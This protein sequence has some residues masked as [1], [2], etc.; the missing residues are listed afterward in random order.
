MPSFPSS[1]S[2][3]N[4]VS[5]RRLSRWSDSKRARRRRPSKRVHWPCTTDN[6]VRNS[7]AFA[8]PPPHSPHCIYTIHRVLY[9]PAAK[10]SKSRLYSCRIHKTYRDPLFSAKLSVPIILFFGSLASVSSHYSSVPVMPTITSRT[11]TANTIKW[12]DVIYKKICVIIVHKWT[13]INIKQSTQRIFFGIFS[14][15]C[16]AFGNTFFWRNTVKCYH[17]Q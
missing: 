17:Y 6:N 13:F 2:T 5:R 16:W 9:Y 8:S 4:P 3:L 7:A 12:Y 1:I 11:T 10:K 15:I 14:E